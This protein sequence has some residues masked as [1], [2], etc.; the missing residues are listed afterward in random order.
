MMTISK[1]L[2][3][4]FTQRCL[5]NSDCSSD[6]FCRRTDGTCDESDDGVCQTK[7]EVCPENYDPVCTCDGETRGNHCEARLNGENVDYE[8]ECS[9]DP[10]P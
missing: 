7:P 8:G 1:L 10:G 4:D 3:P 6:E 9:G 5:D 2:F